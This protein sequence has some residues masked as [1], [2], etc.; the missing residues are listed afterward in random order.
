MNPRL[1]TSIGSHRGL[2]TVSPS[3]DASAKVQPA[4]PAEPAAPAPSVLPQWMRM[5]LPGA[6]HLAP[7][8][9]GIPASTPGTAAAG[10][11]LADSG[12]EPPVAAV[13]AP[14][15]PKSPEAARKKEYMDHLE[16]N[17]D[18][19]IEGFVDL[20][21]Q[22]WLGTPTP[23]PKTLTVGRNH[24]DAKRFI[25]WKRVSYLRTMQHERIASTMTPE[26][27]ADIKARGRESV[28]GDKALLASLAQ[29]TGVYIDDEVRDCLRSYFDTRDHMR[30][31]YRWTFVLGEPEPANSEQ[32]A[33]ALKEMK[34]LEGDE[35]RVEAL[36]LQD[37]TKCPII[38]VLDFVG[39]DAVCSRTGLKYHE[40]CGGSL[41]RPAHLVSRDTAKEVKGLRGRKVRM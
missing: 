27:Q 19:T 15:D 39:H 35:G 14:D 2:S 4:S 18:M 29:R 38:P 25:D 11:A 34:A 12:A 36:E 20:N 41:G 16:A 28:L 7:P 40:C 10:G 22:L 9:L 1:Q 32:Q 3:F 23:L 30:R 17:K 8:S 6:R 24:P 37:R 31:L 26:E 33:N 5:L 21:K 13:Q